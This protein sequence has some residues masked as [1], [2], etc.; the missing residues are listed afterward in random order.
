M[1]WF[2]DFTANYM[3]MF[4]RISYHGAIEP[5]YLA[6]FVRAMVVS[7]SLAMLGNLCYA[8]VGCVSDA[9]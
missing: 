4:H 8:G 6:E 5:K 1:Q 7:S 3:R 9:V 2:L